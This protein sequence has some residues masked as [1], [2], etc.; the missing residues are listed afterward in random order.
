MGEDVLDRLAERRD[1]GDAQ[2]GRGLDR[3][4]SDACKLLDLANAVRLVVIGLANI[5]LPIA[6]AIGDVNRRPQCAIFAGQQ[7]GRRTVN[8]L[9]LALCLRVGQARLFKQDGNIWR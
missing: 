8:G 1:A 4:R 2:A 5:V 9:Q 6:L 7:L 3:G